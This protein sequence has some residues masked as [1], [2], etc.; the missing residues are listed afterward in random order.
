LP[1]THCQQQKEKKYVVS[2]FHLYQAQQSA[3]KVIALWVL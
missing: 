1:A 3:K 2:D